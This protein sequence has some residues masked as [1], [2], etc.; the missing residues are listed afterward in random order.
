MNSH[1][2]AQKNPLETVADQMLA[3]VA[4][5]IELPPSM[6]ALFQ[7]RKQAIQNHLE[8]DG[9]PLKGKIRLF[10]Q[11]GSVAI[12]ATIWAKSREGFDLDIVVE[13]MIPGVTSREALDILCEAM[14]GETGSPYHDMTERQTRC[15][16]VHYS[17]GMRVD[18]SPSEL[19]DEN[20]P[21]RSYIYHSKPEE[22]CGGDQKI[23]A[24]SFGF[25]QMYNQNCPPDSAFAQEYARWAIMADHARN[26]SKNDADSIPVPPHSMEI[27][28]KSVVTVALQLIKLN[29]N[30]RWEYRNERMP[31]SVMLSCL[32]LEV[33]EPDRTIGENL[34]TITRHI[35]D[36]LKSAK[37]QNSLIVVENPI[38]PGDVFTDRWPEDISAQDIMISDMEWLIKQLDI[39]LTEDLSLRDRLRALRKMFGEDLGQSVIKE[40]GDRLAEAIRTGRHRFGDLGGLIMTPTAAKSEPAVKPSTFHGSKDITKWKCLERT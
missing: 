20:D 14:R 30:L 36:R 6:Y 25:A 29:R 27:G 2:A 16:R 37:S 11:Q 3:A 7:E 4:I 33:A 15:V 28:G 10:Y 35:L 13:L 17:D 22:P 8:R 38:C 19:I 9:S 34:Q 26:T 18:L 32:A 1:L 5:K 24:N 12:G 23:L 31:A 39:F 21:R 40:F